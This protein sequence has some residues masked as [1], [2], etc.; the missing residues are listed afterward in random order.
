VALKKLPFRNVSVLLKQ[1]LST[2]EDVK[3]AA[4]IRELRHARLRGYLTRKELEKVC[5]WKSARAIHLIK[6]N[7]VA[8]VC[9]AT[10]RALATRSERG[11]L[12][13]LRTLDGVSVPMA[14]AILMLLD[15]RRYGVIDIRVWQL[16]Y[17]LGEVTKKSTGVGFNFNNWFCPK[18]LAGIGRLPD[19][20]VD[21][22]IPILIHRRLKSQPCQKYRRK[23][24]AAAKPIHDALEAWSKGVDLRATQPKMP[25][26]MSDR[27]EDIWEP[28]LAIA[29][30]IGGDVPE[31]AREAAR[32]LCNNDD[33]LGYGA[34]QLA[35]IRKVVGDQNRITSADLINGLWKADALPSRLMEDDQPNHKKIGHWLSKFITS[36]GGSPARKLRFGEQTLRGYD[37]TDLKSLFDRY[38]PP[39]Q[40]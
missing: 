9:A 18:I 22:S 36:Y 32:V 34:T 15:P 24:K 12:E 3:T 30:A 19:T 5:R 33:E 8:R 28:L 13:A 40:E 26:W 4:L 1:H 29:D 16:L 14:S 20:I 6:H 2:E 23:D 17:A 27:Q 39:E 37:G 7:S 35:A 10:R 25:E 21:R 38:C 31:L 11:R